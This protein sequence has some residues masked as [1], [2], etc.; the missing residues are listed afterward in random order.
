M[1]RRS[2]KVNFR[3]LSAEFSDSFRE[4]GCPISVEAETRYPFLSNHFSGR[5]S[6]SILVL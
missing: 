3:A 6:V 2:F 1:R 5:M 4:R